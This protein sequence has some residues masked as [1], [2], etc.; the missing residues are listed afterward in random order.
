MNWQTLSTSIGLGLTLPASVCVST[1]SGDVSAHTLENNQDF[2]KSHS[3]TVSDTDFTSPSTTNQLESLIIAQNYGQ[4]FPII[5]QHLENSRTELRDYALGEARKF[6]PSNMQWHDAVPEIV[7]NKGQPLL[8]V[9]LHGKLKVPTKILR[10]KKVRLTLKF[11]PDHN[12]RLHYIDHELHVSK[13]RIICKKKRKKFN[14]KL[15]HLLTQRKA[16]MEQAV[17]DK[18][19]QIISGYRF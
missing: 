4:F 19:A 7:W 15:G 17:N 12:L 14:C 8:Q 1:W 18:V 16:Q 5:V 10:D 2:L 9:N 11:Q 6:S 3:L 13:C